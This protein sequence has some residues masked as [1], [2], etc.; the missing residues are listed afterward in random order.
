M[1]VLFVCLGN[2]CRS[3]LAKAVFQDLV[4]RNGLTSHIE[5]DSCGLHNFHEGDTA[6]KRSINTALNHGLKLSHVAR[7]IKP[8]EYHRYNYIIGMDDANIKAL[9]E[10]LPPTTKSKL[11][12]MRYW[13]T[14]APNADVPDPYYGGMEGFE[15]VYKMV[16]RSCQGLLEEVKGNLHL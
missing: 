5:V 14:T 7:K 2:I 1:K 16:S 4:D 15:E 6:D 3:P 13:D 9:K 10:L 8:Q 11:F 12:K